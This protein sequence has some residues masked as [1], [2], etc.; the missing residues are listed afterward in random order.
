MN[1]W[2]LHLIDLK[3]WRDFEGGDVRKAQRVRNGLL[4]KVGFVQGL[5]KQVGLE[6]EEKAEADVLHNAEDESRNSV[7]LLLCSLSKCY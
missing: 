2:H 6:R 3:C 1:H 5:G 7:C 4:E